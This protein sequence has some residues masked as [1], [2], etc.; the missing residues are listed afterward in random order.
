MSKYTKTELDII[1]Q[2]L[3]S[4]LG[5]ACVEWY[6]GRGSE[7]GRVNYGRRRFD[8]AKSLIEKGILKQV[9]I[10]RSNRCDGG[11]TVTTLGMV[12]TWA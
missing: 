2:L 8:A 9:R 5:N 10:D 3:D 7:G 12:V 4:Y 6:V 11:Y 1:R